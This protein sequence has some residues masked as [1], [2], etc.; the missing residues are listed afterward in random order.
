MSQETRLGGAVT[1]RLMQLWEQWLPEVHALR[2]RTDPVEYL[3]VW[4][5]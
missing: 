5:N 1:E 2:I 3:A 4:L